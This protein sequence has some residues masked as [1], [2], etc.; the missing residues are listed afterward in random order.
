MHG[1]RFSPYPLHSTV[2][3]RIRICS[4][5]RL[6]KRASVLVAQSYEVELHQVV[7]AHV[8][9]ECTRQ[10]PPECTA[11]IRMRHDRM[12]VLT[13]TCTVRGSRNRNAC[14]CGE[15]TEV[16]RSVSHKPNSRPRPMASRSAISYCTLPP[17][18][19]YNHACIRCSGVHIPHNR[20]YLAEQTRVDLHQGNNFLANIF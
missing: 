15:W 3:L 7:Y 18:L 10:Q 12:C 11:G 17:I 2:C 6:V 4:R 9:V 8:S 16:G 14:T 5:E 13:T 19:T 20:T 1:G